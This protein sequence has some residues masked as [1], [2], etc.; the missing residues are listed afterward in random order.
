M[1]DM[2]LTRCSDIALGVSLADST[3]GPA[4]DQPAYQLSR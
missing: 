2:S 1:V 3:D 4:T